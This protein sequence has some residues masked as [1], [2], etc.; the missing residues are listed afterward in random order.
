[1]V[2]LHIHLISNWTLSIH[3][4]SIHNI[5]CWTDQWANLNAPFLQSFFL[6][7]IDFDEH[8]LCNKNSTSFLDHGPVSV[9]ESVSFAL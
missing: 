7:I 4:I 1:M 3:T 5:N 6:C 9:N 8:G 2:A